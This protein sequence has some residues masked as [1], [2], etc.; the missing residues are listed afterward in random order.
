[1][2]KATR[3]SG[4]SSAPNARRESKQQPKPPENPL[5]LPPPKPRPK[6][7]IVSAII[8]IAWIVALIALY[9]ATVYP[10]RHVMH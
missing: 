6:L 5:F 1:M 4:K 2:S 10:A 3:S 7:M 9:F 8:L